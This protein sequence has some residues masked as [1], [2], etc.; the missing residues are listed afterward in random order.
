M[1]C[2]SEIHLEVWMFLEQLTHSNLIYFFWIEMLLESITIQLTYLSSHYIDL[3]QALCCLLKN[4]TI[5]RRQAG[6]RGVHVLMPQLTEQ[7]A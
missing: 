3:S 2:R 4:S 1:L 6:A 5:I 7:L